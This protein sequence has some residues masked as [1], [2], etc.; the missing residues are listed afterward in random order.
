MEKSIE[1]KT[2]FA[3]SSCCYLAYG[4]VQPKGFQVKHK[5]DCEHRLKGKENGG[6]SRTNKEPFPMM[7]TGL[8]RLIEPNM[9]SSL[10]IIYVK[11][12]EMI[13]TNQWSLN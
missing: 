7:T 12:S 6:R 10:Q 8:N 11:T 3:S 5:S 13:F 2:I 4:R 9:S 1:S